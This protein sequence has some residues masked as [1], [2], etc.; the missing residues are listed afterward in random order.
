MLKEMNAMM[1]LRKITEPWADEYYMLDQ[2]ALLQ[3][4]GFANVQCRSVSL[5]HRVVLGQAA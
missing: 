3:D 5:R 2:Q 4:N 1:V